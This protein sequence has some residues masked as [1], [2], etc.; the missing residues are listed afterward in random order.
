MSRAGRQRCATPAVILVA[1]AAALAGLVWPSAQRAGATATS[2]LACPGV[3]LAPRLAS[4]RGTPPTQ[5]LDARG[6]Y[7]PVV[8]VHG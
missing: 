3:E 8:M 1:T 2:E 7:V 4:D 6:R 5:T